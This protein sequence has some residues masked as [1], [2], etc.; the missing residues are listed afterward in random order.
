MKTIDVFEK[1][2]EKTALHDKSLAEREKEI[3]QIAGYS[4]S[5]AETI[6]KLLAD[7]R[8]RQS[9]VDAA[10]IAAVLLNAIALL[11]HI[12]ITYI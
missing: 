11:T 7:E 8:R 4:T 5:A 6:A 9:R 3:N 12:F 2:T 10:L 1:L